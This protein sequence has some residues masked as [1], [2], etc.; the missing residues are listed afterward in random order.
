MLVAINCIARNMYANRIIIARYIATQLNCMSNLDVQ[1]EVVVAS[2][3]FG[4][5]S[6]SGSESGSSLLVDVPTEI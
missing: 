2:D 6:A 5:W 4:K 3:S 1:S